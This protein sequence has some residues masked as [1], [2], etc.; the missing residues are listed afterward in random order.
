ML[1]QADPAQLTIEQDSVLPL[2]WVDK[3]LLLHQYRDQWQHQLLITD[4]K[5][6]LEQVE[7]HDQ[8]LQLHVQDQEAKKKD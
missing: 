3:W 5:Q 4:L 1:H 8:N 7:L 6:G 2:Q